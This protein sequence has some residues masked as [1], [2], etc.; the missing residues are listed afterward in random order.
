MPTKPIERLLFIQGKACFF[1]KQEIQKGEATVEHLVAVTHGGKD[2]DENCVACCATL[3]RLLGRMSLKEKFQ[4]CLN[5]K[6]E[7]VCPSKLPKVAM[8]KATVPAPPSPEATKT[9]EPTALKLVASDPFEL[10]VL[11]LQKRGNSRPGKQDRLLNTI[12]STLT[13]HSQSGSLAENIQ[14][15][16]VKLGYVTISETKVS[17]ALP[18]RAA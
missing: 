7:F 10:V 1:C 8:P 9:L 6:G 2:N 12:R 15:R 5:Q 11:D 13:S 3:N 18:K 17:Y 4:I 14:A 16:L